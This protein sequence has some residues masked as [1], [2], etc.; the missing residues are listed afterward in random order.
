MLLF[1]KVNIGAKRA[2][3]LSFEDF[4]LVPEPVSDERF[5]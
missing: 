2:E 5:A 3:D 4:E 1:A